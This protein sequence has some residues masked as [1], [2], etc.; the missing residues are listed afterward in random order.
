MR[1]ARQEAPMK[2]LGFW[3]I[4]MSSVVVPLM[5]SMRERRRKQSRLQSM[6]ATVRDRATDAGES[7][8]DT[9]GDFAETARERL[10]VFGEGSR[11]QPASI[12]TTAGTLLAG[13]PSLVAQFRGDDD[14]YPYGGR[15]DWRKYGDAFSR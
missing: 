14:G 5:R 12:A 7:A 4:V 11:G 15:D 10:G 8:L 1:Q 9:L 13:V 3:L 6:A 2:K